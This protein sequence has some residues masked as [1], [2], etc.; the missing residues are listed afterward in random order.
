[1]AVLERRIQQHQGSGNCLGKIEDC[2]FL[3]RP[4]EFPEIIDRIGHT[5]RKQGPVFYVT[6]DRFAVQLAFVIAFVDLADNR[7]QCM[8][9][10][11]PLVCDMTDHLPH[12]RHLGL[13]D[14]HLLLLTLLCCQLLLFGD[15]HQYL[16][17]PRRLSAAGR[18][19]GTVDH[20]ITQPSLRVTDKDLFDGASA[21]FPV[22]LFHETFFFNPQ[23][24]VAF[25]PDEL[26]LGKVAEGQVRT[27]D[28]DDMGAVVEKNDRICNG[29]Q[30][31]F[32]KQE[33]IAQTQFDLF[34]FFD[35]VTQFFVNPKQVLVFLLH[36]AFDLPF[37]AFKGIQEA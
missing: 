15:I 18:I 29:I 28:S 4:E 1:M 8:Q 22:P 27:V 3:F 34:A 24:F 30:Q 31:G 7:G 20:H 19:L 26:L 17:M 35:L 21:L 14:Q 36:Q 13:L 32:E 6:D 25:F 11:A 37:D 10:L 23:D 33:L 16:H 9:R 5:F 12:C 2:F